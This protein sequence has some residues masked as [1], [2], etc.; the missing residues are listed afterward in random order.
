MQL[1]WQQYDDLLFRSGFDAITWQ[2]HNFA[3]F[4]LDF[5]FKNIIEVNLVIQKLS[6]SK[7]RKNFGVYKGFEMN[8]LH[9][10]GKEF[11][12][13]RFSMEYRLETRKQNIA[14]E[15]VVLMKPF[16]E[17][18]EM[19]EVPTQSERWYVND[20]DKIKSHREHWEKIDDQNVSAYLQSNDRDELEL[21]ERQK[22]ARVIQAMGE[23][24]I[25]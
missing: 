12:P 9:I 4:L 24:L 23:Q 19:F 8:G 21:L 1:G 15:Q 25:L 5:S 7:Q 17:F 22:C 13:S 10:N 6:K 2:L 16:I 3:E 18:D 11:A 20:P 14:I